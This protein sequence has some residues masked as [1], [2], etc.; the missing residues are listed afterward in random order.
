MFL[1]E[2]EH[3]CQRRCLVG[4]RSA[5]CVMSCFADLGAT[6]GV[7]L[8]VVAG[9]AAPQCD[10]EWRGARGGRPWLPFSQDAADPSRGLVTEDR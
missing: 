4:H 7:L 3:A 5:F 1:E 9:Y 2:R 8:S 6:C 10:G